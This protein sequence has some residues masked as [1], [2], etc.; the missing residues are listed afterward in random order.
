MSPPGPAGTRSACAADIGPAEGKPSSPTLRVGQSA[1]GT[2][3]IAGILPSPVYSFGCPTRR[4]C[5]MPAQ[6]A[7]PAQTEAGQFQRRAR[8][9]SERVLSTQA[10]S[11]RGANR[12]SQE[13]G[14]R[15]SDV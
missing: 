9:Q 13:F 4:R 11:F 14:A 8:V 15:R 5:E 6:L 1:V 3:A 12:G 10:F 7:V 2:S